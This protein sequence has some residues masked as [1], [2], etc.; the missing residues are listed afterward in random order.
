MGSFESF[1][2]GTRVANAVLAAAL[3][4]TDLG[5][6][7]GLAV[8][9]PYDREALTPGALA[10][11]AAARVVLT[12]AALLPARRRPW[13]AGGWLRYVGTLVPVLGLVQVG[14]QARADR[15]T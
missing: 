1:P 5:W 12:A 9:Y 3:Y 6:P 4:L 15:Y 7:S 8:P 13:G 11:A 2:L 10:A 14:A